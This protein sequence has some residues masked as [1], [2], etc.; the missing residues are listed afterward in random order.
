MKL[1]KYI[2]ENIDIYDPNNMEKNIEELLNQKNYNIDVDPDPYLTKQYYI[3]FD[4]YDAAVMAN[5]L[6]GKLADWQEELEI[7]KEFLAGN[8]ELWCHLPATLIP[9]AFDGES[10]R[11]NIDPW[12]SQIQWAEYEIKKFED[13]YNATKPK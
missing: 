7:M 5:I 1:S 9:K 8:E 6:R 2:A 12:I 11:E 10:V 3:P 13:V 4:G